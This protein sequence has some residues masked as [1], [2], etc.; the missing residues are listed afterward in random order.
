MSSLNL[1]YLTS[2]RNYILRRFSDINKK[3]NGMHCIKTLTKRLSGA[4]YFFLA[5]RQRYFI[6]IYLHFPNLHHVIILLN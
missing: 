1:L 3:G 2:C 6:T 5:E 4:V